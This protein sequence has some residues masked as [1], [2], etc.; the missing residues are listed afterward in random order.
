MP[1][2]TTVTAV[3]ADYV[4]SQ[5][6]AGVQVCLAGRPEI[7]CTTT[8][9][10]GAF[11]LN[12]VPAGDYVGLH[13]ALDGYWD[14]NWMYDAQNGGPFVVT[15]VPDAGVLALGA[16]S[17]VEVE[18]TKGIVLFR[19]VDGAIEGVPGGVASLMPSS[20]TEALYFGEGGS[21]AAGSGTGASGQGV[22]GNVTP[23]INVDVIF[24]PP[25]GMSCTPRWGWAGPDADS[26]FALVK[27]RTITMV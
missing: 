2:S 13:F 7:H 19:F 16:T 1:P 9:A 12:D 14:V 5:P 10:D 15:L 3:V 23:D 11:V 25:D 24:T 6:L 8:D 22:I 20:G 17:G 27:P 21:L 26:V 4:G 18:P